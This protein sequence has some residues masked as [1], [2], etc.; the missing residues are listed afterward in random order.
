[1]AF[2][3]IKRWKLPYITRWESFQNRNPPIISADEVKEASPTPSGALTRIG[4]P[5]LSR[6]GVLRQRGKGFTLRMPSARTSL[7]TLFSELAHIWAAAVAQIS[8]LL[9]RRIAFCG[10]W[11]SLKC[12]L[13]P[14]ALPI[15]NRRYSRLQICATSLDRLCRGPAQTDPG[16]NRQ[17]QFL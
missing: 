16:H 6:T 5:P 12:E 4:D 13:R 10:A 15:T 3:P 8:N 1:M 11:D 2:A 14:I 7:S 9:S 17:I